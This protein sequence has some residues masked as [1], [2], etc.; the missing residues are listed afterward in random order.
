[1]QRR[2]A[3]EWVITRI[4]R[5][6]SRGELAATLTI[7]YKLRKGFGYLPDRWEIETP[8]SRSQFRHLY[9]GFR[10][11]CRM[12]APDWRGSNPTPPYRSVTFEKGVAYFTRRD[13]SRRILSTEELARPMRFIELDREGPVR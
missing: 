9:F 1:M 2:S 6:S 11:E 8:R 5:T 10:D 7:D 3:R 12:N 4:V 13:G